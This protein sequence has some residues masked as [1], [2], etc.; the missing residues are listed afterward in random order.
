MDNDIV[1]GGQMTDQS[2]LQL[3]PTTSSWENLLTLD[4]V[5]VNHVSWTPVSGIGTYLM[6]GSAVHSGWTATLIKP[7]GTLNPGFTLPDITR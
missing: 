5:R 3:N 1:C 2:C 7:D 6:G 4:D